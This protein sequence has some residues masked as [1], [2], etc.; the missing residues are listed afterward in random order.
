MEV[1]FQNTNQD[2]IDF[3]KIRLNKNLKR[4]AP[5]YFAISVLMA[6]WCYSDRNSYSITYLLICSLSPVAI[7]VILYFLQLWFFA[8]RLNVL[9]K[10]KKTGFEKKK[11]VVTNDGIIRVAPEKEDAL[12]K[13]ESITS[14][15]EDNKFFYIKLVNGMSVL[16][17]RKSFVSDAEGANFLG[18]I[19]SKIFGTNGTGN[20][21]YSKY[22][23]KPKPPYWLGFLGII[24][25]A[26]AIVGLILI[27]LGIFRYRNIALV[28]L[29]LIG[30]GFSVVIYNIFPSAGDMMKDKQTRRAFAEFSKDDLNSLVKEIEFYKIQNSAYPDSLQQIDTKGSLT[31]IYDPLL[32][33]QKN[34]IFNYHK[35]GTKYTL[36]SSGE[37]Q[38]PNTADDIYPTIDTT[39]TGLIIKKK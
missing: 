35:I 23:Q 10:R 20:I 36:F 31:N 21:I 3:H 25:I 11:I 34:R 14:I 17:P 19:R 5:A 6:V 12:Y 22:T 39:H 28:I 26:G 15:V 4:Q 9:I 8:I 33:G 16:I 27:I 38:K 1:E 18:E 32:T 30:I 2:F 7:V 37:D 24:P 13:W 29:G